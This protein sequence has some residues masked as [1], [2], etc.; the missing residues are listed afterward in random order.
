MN[1]ISTLTKF[2]CRDGLS[3]V[4]ACK[5]VCR[6]AGGGV[7]TSEKNAT[8]NKSIGSLIG[9]IRSA[10]TASTVESI[11]PENNIANLAC[12]QPLFGRRISIVNRLH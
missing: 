8:F 3:S 10:N 2:H 9:N 12:S 11:P 7:K 1:R 4:K 5:P 6:S